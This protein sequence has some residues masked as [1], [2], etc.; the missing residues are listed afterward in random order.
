[1]VGEGVDSP[2]SPFAPDN[3]WGRP[4]DQNNY[5]EHDVDQA[6]AEVEPY[7]T[8][9]GESSLK[10]TL[11]SAADV[12]TTR[13]AQLV[14]SQWQE[15]G[16]EVDIEAVEAAAL[17]GNLISGKYETSI[18]Q[19][20]NAPDPDQFHYFWSADTISGY[21]GININLTQFSNDQMEAAIKTGRVSGDTATRKAAYDEV[22]DQINANAT[23]IWLYWNPF[24]LIA[25]KNVH[26]LEGA[27][28]VPFTYANPKTWFGQLWRG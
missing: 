16:I 17:I 14:Q 19:I 7:K 12:D 11:T 27:K 22:V 3:P 26:G 9:T 20:Y 10:V 5:P 24:S 13:I 21:G 25:D 28:A 1:M 6:K 2:T 4:E 23:N 8:D 15:A 18:L